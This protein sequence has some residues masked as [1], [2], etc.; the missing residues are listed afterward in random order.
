MGSGAETARETVKA[1]S[2]SRREGRRPAGYASTGRSRRRIF[3][4]VL[5]AS[6]TAIAVLEQTKE[7]GSTGEPLY[8]D[9]VATLA[10]AVGH[11]ARLSM[12]QVIGG[13]YGLSS[14]D[15]TPAMAKAA[16]D[17]LLTRDRANRFSGR[18][19][20]TL[21]I[22]DDVSHTS[23]AL[24]AGFSIEADYRHPGGVLR[25]RRRWHGRREQ[26]Q[27]EDHRRGRR[28]LCAGLFRLR[29]RTSRAP[30]PSL[31]SASARTRS[32]RPT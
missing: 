10:E 17:E 19:G 20:F 4:G 8:L 29:F 23:L 11:G 7:P 3:L 16:L 9:V 31:I 12:P 5:P 18:N 25:P 13:R 28:A 30:R 32:R 2:R 26:E 15:F 22:D 14:K 6:V 27:R 21:G 1:L 24:D